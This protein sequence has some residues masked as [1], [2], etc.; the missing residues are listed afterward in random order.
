MFVNRCF[1]WNSYK[2]SAYMTCLRV[3]SC[4][5]LSN[6]TIRQGS[7]WLTTTRQRQGRATVCHAMAAVCDVGSSG[8]LSGRRTPH[9][10][11]SVEG[12]SVTDRR[13][14]PR[15]PYPGS[16]SLNTAAVGRNAADVDRLFGLLSAVIVVDCL[17]RFAAVLR[18]IFTYFN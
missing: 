6:R 8:V 7:F 1:W 4:Y 15:R 11:S 17:R 3:L 13:P 10:T 14:R 5:K 2:L 9:A 18:Q 12:P 16:R